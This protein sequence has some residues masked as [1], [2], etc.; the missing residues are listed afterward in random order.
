MLRYISIIQAV[1]EGK[2]DGSSPAGG[3]ITGSL[4][5][6]FSRSGRNASHSR[7]LFLV[8]LCLASSGWF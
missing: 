3:K 8:G 5:R 7:V 6:I 4:L 2:F 1:L